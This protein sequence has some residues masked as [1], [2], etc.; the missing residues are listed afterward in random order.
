MTG[1]D[2]NVLW[3]WL[4]VDLG[5]G[6]GGDAIGFGVNPA[7]PDIAMYT[8]SGELFITTDGGKSWSQAMS[9]Q[10]TPGQ[11]KKGDLWQSNGLEVTTTW[12]YYFDPFDKDRTYICYTDIGFARSSDRGTQWQSATK[13]SPWQNTFYE[14]AFDPAQKGVLYA[15]AASQHDIPSWTNVD[16]AKAG[17][18]VV[19]ST[20]SGATWQVVSSGLPKNNPCTSVTLDPKS[21]PNARTLYAAMFGDGVYKSTD[22]GKS[23]QKKPGVGREGNFH[24]YAVRFGPDGALYA[25]V[26]GKR[27]GSSFDVAG[28][29]WRSADGGDTWTELTAGQNFWWPTE[30]AVH[31]RDPKKIFLSNSDVPQKSGGG[32]YAT[33]D[34][35][36]SWKPVLLSKDLDQKILNYSHPFAVTFAPTN[37]DV[38][39][40]STWTHGL[41]RS[42]D[43]GKTWKMMK[44][45]PFIT[46]N[47]VS[48]D[49][50]DPNMIYVTTFGGGVWKGRTE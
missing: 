49:P 19:K 29:L 39:Y 16:R 41:Q 24:V 44:G 31:P 21:D 11:P 33:E 17:G 9:T 6:W 38:M 5:P 43:G 10:I 30:F 20:D 47:R 7:Y 42:T 4:A 50:A 8:N 32:L 12:Q 37:P 1:A 46:I 34:G 36:K 15:A 35:G 2:Q 3:G 27:N 25:L 45:I 26:T 18:G 14:L 23:W 13:G 40:L 22:G 28:G 48:F